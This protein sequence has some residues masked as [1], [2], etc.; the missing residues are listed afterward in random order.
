MPVTPGLFDD[1]AGLVQVTG[2]GCFWRS[3]RC[4][5]PSPWHQSVLPLP[6][7]S[8]SGVQ[9]AAGLLFHG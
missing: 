4:A 1:A 7:F 2:R 6:V 5:V 9:F 3:H 8:V